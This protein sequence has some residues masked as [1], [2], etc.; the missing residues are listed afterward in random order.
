MSQLFASRGQS[1]GA[2]GSASVLSVNI[3]GWFSLGWTGLIWLFKGLSR[4]FSLIT[5]GKHQFFSAQ[6]S[7]WVQLTH[8]YMTT[9]KTIGVTTRTFVG[10]VMSLLLNMLSRFVIAFPPRSKHFLISWL[11]SPSVVILEPRKIKSHC[12]HCFPIYLPWSDG[13]RW[14]DLSFLNAELS[15]SFFTLLF[16]KRLF[17]SSSLSAIRVVSFAYLR[18]LIFLPAIFIPAC[19][20]PSLAFL[21]MYSA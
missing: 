14:H 12:F 18:L 9:G 20:S 10:K 17:S 16:I 19:A 5:V 4:V 3:Q 2:L 7:L 15:A 1:I 11:K 21:M 6:S 13:I 8:P